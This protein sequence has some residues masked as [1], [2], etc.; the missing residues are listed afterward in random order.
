MRKISICVTT[1]NRPSIT[2]DSFKS[3]VGDP[4]VHEVVIFDDGSDIQN[5]QLLNTKIQEL[6]SNKVKY[7]VSEVNE[8]MSLAKKKAIELA[9]M[10]WVIILDSDNVIDTSY[11]DKLFTL[12][13]WS[14]DTIYCPS[15]AKPHFD[16]RKFE[17]EY[18]DQSIVKIYML[19]SAFLKLINTCNYFVNKNFYLQVYSYNKD[20]KATD[21]MWH[22]LN[23]LKADGGFFIVPGM[24]Y[25]HAVH[26]QSGWRQDL[27]ENREKAK[28]IQKMIMEL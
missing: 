25:S 27:Q 16:Y 4:R 9:E 6:G 5:Q 22:N 28:E 13:T 7:Y 3:V 14:H 10:D 23:H 2:L 20:V 26:E 18:I 24:H 19:E 8:G 17:G 15:F 12:G 11:L 1:F 21:T